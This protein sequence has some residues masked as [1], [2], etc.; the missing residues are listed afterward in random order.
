M[1]RRG[2]VAYSGSFGTGNEQAVD[3]NKL[4]KWGKSYR[5]T[6]ADAVSAL[7]SLTKHPDRFDALKPYCVEVV[8]ADGH[9]DEEV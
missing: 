7:L 1:G 4:V 3:R 6:P 8:K 9:I 2:G 5:S